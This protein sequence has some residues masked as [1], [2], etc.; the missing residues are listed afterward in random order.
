MV[1]DTGVGKTAIVEGLVQ[2]IVQNR[3]PKPLSHGTVYS[4]D[5]G[6]LLSSTK[7]WGDFENG[8]SRY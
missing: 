5:L 3:V 6:I 2:L 8:L 4:L 7:Y 1:G